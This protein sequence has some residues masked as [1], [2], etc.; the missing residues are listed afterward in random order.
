MQHSPAELPMSFG[1]CIKFFIFRMI[2]L[3]L[4]YFRRDSLSSIGFWRT[5]TSTDAISWRR[6]CGRH[7]QIRRRRRLNHQLAP[8]VAEATQPCALSS[9]EKKMARICSDDAAELKKIRRGHCPHFITHMLW[10]RVQSLPSCARHTTVIC[11]SARVNSH[12]KM[13]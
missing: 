3:I 7:Q 5:E 8:P 12:I 9:K 1:F 10:R 11:V 4:V 13:C 6:R 2:L